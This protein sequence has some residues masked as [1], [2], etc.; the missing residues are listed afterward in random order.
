MSL[1]FEILSGLYKTELQVKKNTGL[2]LHAGPGHPIRAIPPKF[3]PG[4]L[5]A[6]RRLEF[7]LIRS[8][9]RQS[10]TPWNHIAAP[11]IYAAVAK[12]TS[13]CSVEAMIDND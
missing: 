5:C 12:K 1:I 4:A 3:Y 9:S 10:L 7:L 8:L 13:H 6:P 2:F 11:A